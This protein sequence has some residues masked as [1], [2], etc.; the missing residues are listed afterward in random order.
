MP[1]FASLQQALLL[2]HEASLRVLSRKDACCVSLGTAPTFVQGAAVAPV[3]L[4]EDI[5]LAGVL[6]LSGYL[7]LRDQGVV[8]SGHNAQTPV[9]MCHGTDDKYVSPTP[10]S[11]LTPT[12]PFHPS[13][14]ARR[15]H[16]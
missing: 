11:P 16:V 4:K 12:H 15:R 7:T 3:S 6:S 14:T 5:T 9:L 2:T 1:S 10:P 13:S 8:V